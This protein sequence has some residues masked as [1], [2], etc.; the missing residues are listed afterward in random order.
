MP[1]STRALSSS[2]LKTR[3]GLRW[4][5]GL[6]LAALVAGGLAVTMHW[7]DRAL[8]WAKEY[9]ESPAERQESTWL[10]DYHVD[11]DAK[12]LPGMEDDEASDLAYDPATRTLFS[13]MGKNPFLVQLTL[14]GEVL[15]K[16]PLV[17]WSN[18]EGVAVLEDGRLAI[19]DERRHD[20]VVVRV[21][22]K[23]TSLD[24]ADFQ[25]HDLGD[26]DKGNKGF[27]A[28]VWDPRRHRL[29]IGEERPP[30]LFAWNSDGHGNLVGEKHPLPSDQ[31]DLR[32]LSATGMDP[33]TGHLLALSANSNMLLELD[34]HG[35]QI[36]FMTLLG[37]FN[38]LQQTLPRAE[39]V[40]MDEQGTL[41]MVSEPNLFYR[42]SKD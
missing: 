36:S 24:R 18:P 8:L 31:L 19:V 21:D 32:N 20:L 33:R 17:G 9:F 28:V 37:G 2:K 4:P 1:V 29:I 41:Y 23:T 13:V 10:P 42:F 3:I 39:G 40:A 14:D 26:A 22:A 7:D 12:V 34:E 25:A 38:G 16:I 5:L 27:E 15:R 35:E 11:I 6:G 30:R